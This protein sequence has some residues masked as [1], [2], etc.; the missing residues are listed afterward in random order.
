MCMC[1]NLVGKYHDKS[2]KVLSPETVLRRICTW[3]RLTTPQHLCC[4]LIGLINPGFVGNSLEGRGRKGGR[5][6]KKEMN[7]RTEQQNQSWHQLG[8][9][10]GVGCVGKALYWIPSHTLTMYYWVLPLSPVLRGQKLV[11]CNCCLIGKGT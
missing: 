3:W 11:S 4:T 10:L 6:R 1:A 2:M 9:D 8:G 7:E 5:E